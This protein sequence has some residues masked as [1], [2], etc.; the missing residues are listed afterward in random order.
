ML[1]DDALRACCPLVTLEATANIA[2]QMPEDM[3]NI[4]HPH[5]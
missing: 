3:V 2:W 4:E 1:Y 5:F